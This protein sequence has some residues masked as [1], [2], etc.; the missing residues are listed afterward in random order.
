MEKAYLIIYDVEYET[1]QEQVTSHILKCAYPRYVP[2]SG[3]FRITEDQYL[4]PEYRLNF[5]D[6]T[7]GYQDDMITAIRGFMEEC[8]PS[9]TRTAGDKY[10]VLS[11][12]KQNNY[13][14]WQQTGPWNAGASAGWAGLGDRTSGWGTMGNGAS[15]GWIGEGQQQAQNA[16]QSRVQ[17]L[18]GIKYYLKKVTNPTTGHDDVIVCITEVFEHPSVIIEGFFKWILYYI[19]KFIS[20]SIVIE[21]N[22]GKLSQNVKMVVSSYFYSPM[23][24]G[25]VL[26]F[27]LSN[28]YN[29]DLGQNVLFHNSFLTLARIKVA[30]KDELAA[31]DNIPANAGLNATREENIRFSEIKTA[32][33]YVQVL[34]PGDIHASVNINAYANLDYEYTVRNEASR[35][36][37][38]YNELVEIMKSQQPGGGGPATQ[39]SWLN[40]NSMG[41]GGMNNMNPGFMGGQ[42]QQY[43]NPGFMGG[44]QQPFGGPQYPNNGMYPGQ[45]QQ[46]FGGPQYPNNGMYYPPNN[47]GGSPFPQ[48]G[49]PSQGGQ[50]I[51]M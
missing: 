50:Y 7:R 29:K 35:R 17:F 28:Y 49:N 32:L 31:M 39:A 30:H 9:C 48:G 33:G 2:D 8:N 19:F 22:L 44:Q 12:S 51:P 24:E 23:M 4:N 47:G 27:A 5:I 36:N 3:A 6:T 14:Y 11:V 21:L 34:S 41:M 20:P 1:R 26:Y 10:V 18:A 37:M 16:N 40:T 25:G 42:Q 45:P 46:Q 13:N 38:T 15:E 43:M